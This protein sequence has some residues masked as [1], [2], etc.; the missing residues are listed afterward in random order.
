MEE[1]KTRYQLPDLSIFSFF[2][3]KL[4]ALK[5]AQSEADLKRGAREESNNK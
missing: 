2:Q 5:L 4:D 3:R 1:D